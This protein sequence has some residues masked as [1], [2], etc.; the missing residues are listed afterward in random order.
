MAT[1]SKRERKSGS[2]YLADV[3]IR[4]YPRQKK[5]FKRLT[6]AKIWAQQTEAAIRSG[7][8]KNVGK[9]AKTKTLRDVI[10]RYQVDVLPHKAPS[11]Q[12][13]ESRIIGRWDKLLGT[14]TLSRLSSDL[15]NDS[16][17]KLSAEGD[18]R[19]KI[20]GKAQS[21]A[22]PKSRKT[23][24]HYRDLL[25]LLLS[26]SQKW[27]WMGDDPMEGVRPITKLRNERTRYLDDDER[28]AL[29]AACKA[30]HNRQLYPIVVFALSTGA[31]KGEILGLTLDDVSMER[32]VA[33]FRNT[34]N[35][36]TRSVPLVGH[37]KDVLKKQIR[38][39][40]AE[41]K[42]QQE[43]ATKRWL[44]PGQDG[45]KPIDIR[46]PWEKARDAAELVDF[47]FHDLRHSTA[48]YL[49]MSGAS[50]L[51]IAEVLGH[52]TLQM[53]KRYAHLSESHVRGLVEGLDKSIFHKQTAENES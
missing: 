5:T 1:I 27:G 21:P 10:H 48:S 46:N 32:E 44:F 37:L 43:T 20:A 53:V 39:S 30:S 42:K 17:R 14:T 11:T 35:G 41:H 38:W 6:D 45:Q 24:K 28:R 7:E 15:I 18:R 52:R 19:L 23:M 34:K 36:D 50:Q 25:A 22:R 29:L 26:H 3:R 40:K 2:V 13:M 33:V 12:E 31:R 8:F 4:G 9:T 51:E 49:A 47:R 16:L